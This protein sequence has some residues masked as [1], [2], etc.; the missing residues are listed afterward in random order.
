MR[1]EPATTLKEL[2]RESGRLKQLVEHL[3]LD[4]VS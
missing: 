4:I 2:E 1:T 3:S